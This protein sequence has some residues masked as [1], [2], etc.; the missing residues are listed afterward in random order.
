[1]F[2]SFTSFSCFMVLAGASSTMLN[3]MDI[4]VIFPVAG[5]SD[6]SLVINDNLCSYMAADSVYSPFYLFE[7]FLLLIFLKDICLGKELDV[8]SGFLW[9]YKRISLHSLFAHII[10]DKKH[11]FILIF[12]SLYL[13]CFSPLAVL[14]FS[15]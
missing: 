1:M 4:L 13:M 6:L 10:S 5:E 8:D 3:R 11:A 14:R 7:K 15:F 12:I 2:F 9:H